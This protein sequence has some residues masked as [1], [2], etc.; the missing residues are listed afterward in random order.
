MALGFGKTVGASTLGHP[1]NFTV[2]LR[3]DADAD[4]VAPE[5]ACVKAEVVAGDRPLLAD[6]VQVR[7]ERVPAT[8][9]R[10]IRVST[11][12]VIDEPVVSITLRVGCPVNLT[13]NFVLFVD[14]PTML[15]QGGATDPVADAPSAVV[16]GS[17]LA[18]AAAEG[19]AGRTP[20]RPARPPA[21]KAPRHAEQA[22]T[23]R[24]RAQLAL[25]TQPAAASAPIP[26][27]RPPVQAKAPVAGRSVLQL[28]PLEADASIAPPLR[29]A[30][31]LA[32]S[33][34]PARSASAV[35][36]ADPELSQRL[37][38]QA[39]VKALEE[40]LRQSQEESQARQK[41]LA[42]FDARSTQVSTR[43]PAQV[44]DESRLV[45]LLAA[46]CALL[47]FAVGVLAWLRQRDR[48]RAAWWSA[49]SALSVQPDDGPAGES[50]SP[51]VSPSGPSASP[52]AARYPRLDVA[53]SGAS[54][55]MESSLHGFPLPGGGEVVAD[56]RRPMSA[57]ELID[58]EQ[59]VEFFVVL[60]QDDAA[61]DLLMGHV[62]STGG[63]NPLPYL[64]LFEIYRR[65]EEREP[66]E[67]I[68]ER[69][70][71]RFN[72]YAPEWGTDPEAG[73]E[74]EAYPEVLTRLQVAWTSPSAAVALLD[75]LLFKRDAGPTFEVPAYR[76]LLFLYGTARELCEIDQPAPAVDL[77]LPIDDV[78]APPAQAPAA[79]TATPVPRL[80]EGE[81]LLDLDISSEQAM[82]DLHVGLPTTEREADHGLEFS[83]DDRDL[84]AFPSKKR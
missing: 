55:S 65:R 16:R 33:P 36:A 39:R 1:L 50:P 31:S 76:Q 58:L 24:R 45:Y 84:P 11:S 29:M 60:G 21:V 15:A 59:Q 73:Q 38:D 40:A 77:L 51:D 34:D 79:K 25:N 56:V 66:Y 30:T 20:L 83:L 82:Q 74:L 18:A 67:R 64:K 17:A 80:E 62:R 28:D 43:P 13:R 7:L 52:A 3:T 42:E 81:L 9:E 41:A 70:N 10:R 61:I 27:L 63:A 68:R 37:R 49:A 69:F 46:L 26:K 75:V 44:A 78:V 35:D 12:Q 14:P 54:P 32:T 5:P 48:Q 72:A 22:E 6:G 23:P 53:V 2:M 8:G 4:D 57:E 19:S 47:A 71:R